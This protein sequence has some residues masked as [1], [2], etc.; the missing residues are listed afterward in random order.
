MKEIHDTDSELQNL[1]DCMLKEVVSNL[2]NY[3][4]LREREEVQSALVHEDL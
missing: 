1:L 3:E 2:L 4:Y